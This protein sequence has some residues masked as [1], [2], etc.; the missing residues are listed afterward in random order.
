[1]SYDYKV[2]KCKRKNYL[3][4]LSSDNKITLR[5]PLNAT[6]QSIDR[7][8]DSKKEWLN[9]KL[10][11]HNANLALNESLIA[12]K[13]V[14]I[15]GKF[16]NL[17]LGEKKS[18]DGETLRL[19]TLSQTKK[20][21]IEYF[22]EKFIKTVDDLCLLTGLN[23]SKII[24]K[25]YKSRWGCCSTKGVLSFNYRLIMLPPSLQ[26]YV[27]IHELCHLK[28]MNHSQDFWKF[29]EK[30]VPNYKVLRKNLKAYSFII[31]LYP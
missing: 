26:G 10:K 27:I 22:S 6:E 7:F 31:K 9:K 23:Y 24:I 15:F 29:V 3:L 14:L 25:G 30:F 18:F 8:L 2:I 20:V 12:Y 21:I 19:K 1:M 11:E 17:T 4:S 5:V 13:S 16:Y 28:F